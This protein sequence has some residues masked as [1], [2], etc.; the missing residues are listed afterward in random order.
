MRNSFSLIS[1]LC[2]TILLV[3]LPGMPAGSHLQNTAFL[4]VSSLNTSESRLRPEAIRIYDSLQLEDYGLSLH[5]FE[6]AYK[7]YHYLAGKGWLNNPGIITICDFSQSSAKKRL[8]V[9]DLNRYEILMTTY[10]AHGKNSGGEYAKKFSNKPRSHQ[11]S[12]GF[13]ITK[14]SYYGEHGLALRLS[15]VEKGINDN[16][17]SR[18]IVLHGAAYA[19]DEFLQNNP[20]LGRSYG[21][22]AIP[23]EETEKLIGAIKNGTCL[24][25]YH[26]NE[27]YLAASKILNG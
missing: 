22:P 2:I 27:K 23:K 15:G 16:A 10:V 20:F 17:F 8:Y 12:L 7:G 14:N 5:A 11:S 25:I 26:P 19:S 4:H 6:Y 3:S 18:N 21:C 13:Y 9:I 1:V 24:F